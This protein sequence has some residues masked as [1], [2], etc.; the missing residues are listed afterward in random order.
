VLYYIILKKEVKRENKFN[1]Q[2]NHLHIATK[3][4]KN[5]GK[6]SENINHYRLIK[7]SKSVIL[8]TLIVLILKYKSII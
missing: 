2:F 4:M 6:Y 7:N 1:D 5:L 3:V 8:I